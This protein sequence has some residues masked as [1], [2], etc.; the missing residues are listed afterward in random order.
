M[1]DEI[2]I[3][4]NVRDDLRVG[5]GAAPERSRTGSDARRVPARQAAPRAR[6]IWDERNTAPVLGAPGWGWNAG[7]AFGPVGSG[8][9]VWALVACGLPVFPRALYP[10]FPSG[11]CRPGDYRPASTNEVEMPPAPISCFGRAFADDPGAK[12]GL[13]RKFVCGRSD[14]R[15]RGIRA[16]G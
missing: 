4:L 16:E 15:P 3:G 7:P 8:S 9:R 11:F 12:L 1:A 6:S 14:Y 13:W 2:A 10:L 5:G